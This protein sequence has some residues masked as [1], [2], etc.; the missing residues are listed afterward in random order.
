MIRAKLFILR[1]EID[2]LWTDMDYARTTKSDGKPISEVLG[3][4]ITMAFEASHKTDV[5]TRWMTKNSEDDT[6]RESDLME[7]GEIRFFDEDHEEAPIR[8]YKFS[9]AYPYHYEEVFDAQSDEQFTIIMSISPAV[10]DYGSQLVKDWNV[11]YLP[12][13]D[14]GPGESQE[15]EKT[16]PKFLGYHFENDKGE[17]IEQDAIRIDDVIYLIVETENAD[18]EKI[19][20]SL[21]DDKLDYKHNGKVLEND[22]IKGVSVTG[23]RTKIKLTAVAQGSGKSE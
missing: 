18:G 16:E 13:S 6:F 19:T 20:L 11:S 17:K 8:T 12:P 3:G 10:Q 15:E 2:L 1:Q 9:D 23:D 14:P 22:T 5:L 21:D 7:E 4:H